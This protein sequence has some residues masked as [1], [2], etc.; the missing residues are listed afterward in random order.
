MKGNDNTPTVG[1]ASFKVPR[2][3]YGRVNDLLDD[4][5]PQGTFDIFPGFKAN[6]LEISVTL[7]GGMGPADVESITKKINKL[8][9]VLYEKHKDPVYKKVK[10]SITDLVNEDSYILDISL[11]NKN[12][13]KDIST[14]LNCKKEISSILSEWG[15]RKNIDGATYEEL[16][17]DVSPEFRAI[18]AI[19]SE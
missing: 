4:Y 6:N 2:T 14:I 16:K 13:R 15:L 7:K 17:R 8:P 18:D 12:P 19:L 5:T 10:V 9:D 11:K 3:M 1:D